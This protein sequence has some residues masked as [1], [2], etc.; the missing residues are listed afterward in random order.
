MRAILHFSSFKRIDYILVFLLLAISGNPYI[1]YWNL[2]SLML[3][4]FLCARFLVKQH[5]KIIIRN[6]LLQ[7]KSYIGAFILLFCAQY[8]LC[9]DISIVTQINYIFKIL[10]GSLFF[11]IYGENFRLLYLKVI[12]FIAIVSLFFYPLVMSGLTIPNIFGTGIGQ[13][14]S[15]SLHTI[16]V[17]NYNTEFNFARNCGMF[18][19]PG[20]YACYLC[21]TPLLFI[22]NLKLFVHDNKKS[23]IILVLALLTTQS[24]TGFLTFS[25]LMFMILSKTNRYLGPLIAFVVILIIFSSDVVVDK[26]ARDTMTIEGLKL[27]QKL[28]YQG[29]ESA[30]RLGTVFFLFPFFMIHPFIGNG[31]NTEA[32]FS[33]VKFLI[34]EKLG[35]GNGFMIY[36]V[37]VG[38][39]GCA[40]Y[41]GKLWKNW[42]VGKHEKLFASIV[43]LALLQGEPLLMYPIFIGLPFL[44]F[45]R[46]KFNT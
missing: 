39:I 19:E 3:L 25:L 18:W 31:L 2:S 21:L 27:G 7:I 9:D 45:K 15:N 23:V 10:C 43:I 29:Y 42:N 22:D 32:M 1:C 20:C 28:D 16:I 8:L 11:I 12:V 14:G 36:L 34:T 30:N 33:S 6:A 24:T 40:M 5:G 44:T 37:Q 4:I 17:Y 38:V 35:L 41:L 46:N 13:D 26:F